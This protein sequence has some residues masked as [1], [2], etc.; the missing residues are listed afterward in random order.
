MR[1]RKMQGACEIERCVIER[2]VSVC[3]CE[4]VHVK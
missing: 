1:D 4:C 3:M 2:C